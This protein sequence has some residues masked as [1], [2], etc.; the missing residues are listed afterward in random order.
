MIPYT[1]SQVFNTF[2][3]GMIYRAIKEFSEKSCISW[4]PRDPNRHPDFVHILKDRGC[5]SKVGR[6][7]GPQVLSLG[8]MHFKLN[9][10]SF[11]KMGH[12][13][14][15][16]L[17]YGL[18]VFSIQFIVHINFGDDWIWPVVFWCW[19]RPLYQLRH[20]NKKETGV[21]GIEVHA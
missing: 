14:P 2:E 10:I 8:Q 18:L 16:F 12:S 19:K 7:R 9:N 21:L 13:R 17:Y 1:V 4:I 3:R 5:Y 15:P 20:N 6:M 11:I